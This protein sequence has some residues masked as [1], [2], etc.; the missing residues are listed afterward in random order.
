[1][2]TI[3]AG[4]YTVELKIDE[5]GYRRELY[6]KEYKKPGGDFEN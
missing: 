1:M 4:D 2:A 6:N 3:T 5:E